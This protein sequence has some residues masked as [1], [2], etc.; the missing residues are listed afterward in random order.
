MFERFTG[1]ARR[2]LVLAQEEGRLLDHN[3]ISTEHILLGLLGCSGFSSVWSPISYSRTGRL[4]QDQIAVGLA[5]RYLGGAAE[6]VPAGVEGV[7]IEVER[8]VAYE[9]D[10]RF[11][12]DLR[13]GGKG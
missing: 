6:H 11:E 3:F 4:A 12:A 5:D 1:R 2:V 7:Y 10:R 8:S 13:R 9:I